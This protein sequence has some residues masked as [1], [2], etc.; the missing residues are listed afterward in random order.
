MWSCRKFKM[1]FYQINNPK[2]TELG[3]CNELLLSLHLRRSFFSVLIQFFQI[4]FYVRVLR[5]FLNLFAL[6]LSV[7]IIFV[8]YNESHKGERVRD[9]KHTLCALTR[10]NFPLGTTAAVAA[11]HFCFIIENIKLHHRPYVM[12]F[13]SAS[14][15]KT[16]F[17]LCHDCL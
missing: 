5:P 15:R 14:R 10:R 1:R 12:Q 3:L 17:L 13:F 9:C 7:H 16:Y 6:S 4:L 8:F 11:E 2:G